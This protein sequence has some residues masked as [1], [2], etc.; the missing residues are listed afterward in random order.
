MAGGARTASGKRDTDG[1]TD[2]RTRWEKCTESRLQRARRQGGEIASYSQGRR[3]K[4]L[5]KEGSGAL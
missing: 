2:R 1:Q 3:R 4:L 5:S